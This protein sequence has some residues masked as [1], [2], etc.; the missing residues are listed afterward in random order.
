LIE[1]SVSLLAKSEYAHAWKGAAVEA[2]SCLEKGYSIGGMRMDKAAEGWPPV[3]E[4]WNSIS[5]LWG[6]ARANMLHSKL[7]SKKSERRGLAE[8]LQRGIRSLASD[9]SERA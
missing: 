5:G 1:R 2:G 7:A 8:L 3:T 6:T 4:Y 9:A